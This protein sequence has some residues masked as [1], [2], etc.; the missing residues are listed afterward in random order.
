MHPTVADLLLLGKTHVPI[1]PHWATS[2][3]GNLS[4][5]PRNSSH[6]LLPSASLLGLMPMLVNA[7][8]EGIGQSRS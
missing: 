6:P 8:H 7:S 5:L 1:V 3:V 4:P 2:D